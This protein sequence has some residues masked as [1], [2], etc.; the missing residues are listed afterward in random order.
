MSAKSAALQVG[1]SWILR[2]GVALSVVLEAA[3][4]VLNYARTGEST[5]YPLDAMWRVSGGNFFDFTYSAA[6]SLVTGVTP[7][8]LVSLGVVA[9][10]FTPYVRVAAAVVYY[11]VEKDW[12]YVAITSFV[13]LLITVALLIF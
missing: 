5:L 1:I 6:R 10:M 3:G 11:G 8:A 4:V 7:I 2:V 9:L 12:K 13:F